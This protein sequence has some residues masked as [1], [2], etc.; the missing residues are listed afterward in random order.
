MMT[1]W[2][3]WSFLFFRSILLWFLKVSRLSNLLLSFYLLFF[4][5]RHI[6]FLIPLPFSSSL[7]LSSQ[8][9]QT[10]IS[11]S[12][13]KQNAKTASPPF[14]RWRSAIKRFQ[15]QSLHFLTKSFVHKIT[16]WYPCQTTKRG[17][18][19]QINNQSYS[20]M[21]SR[22]TREEK[23]TRQSLQNG[24]LQKF[25]WLNREMIASLSVLPDITGVR[26]DKTNDS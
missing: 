13:S 25:Q 26:Q 5:R 16:V 24:K 4:I 9:S 22:Q 14:L 18:T 7:S 21:K 10:A 11:R 15:S 23:K 12:K 3:P 17:K 6:I 8:E 1:L 19:N 2:E 20:E